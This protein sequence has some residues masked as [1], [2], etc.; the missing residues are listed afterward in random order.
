M[1]IDVAE[2]AGVVGLIERAA[3]AVAER[4]QAVRRALPV[5]RRVELPGGRPGLVEAHG[6]GRF[7]D[8]VKVALLAQPG[9]FSLPSAADLLRLN[10]E[11]GT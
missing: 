8:R 9:E 2:A 10:P 5:G 6:Y 1:A 3:A 7:G 4:D 11:V